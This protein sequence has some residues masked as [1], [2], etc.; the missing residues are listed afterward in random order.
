MNYLHAIYAGII[1]GLGASAN[2]AIGGLPGAVIFSFALLMI[3]ALKYDLFTGKVGAALIGE[4]KPLHLI[5]A[6]LGNIEGICLVIVLTLFSPI[7]DSITESATTIANLRLSNH[8]ISN[9]MLG[10]LC[11]MCV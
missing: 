10:G 2:L 11:G 6:Y 4:Y 1:I 7:A 9:I 3:C 5:G 8:W